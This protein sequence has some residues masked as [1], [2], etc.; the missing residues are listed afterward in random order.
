MVLPLVTRVATVGAAAGLLLL[1]C[2]C[3]DGEIPAGL[4]RWL[5]ALHG[6]FVCL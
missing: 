6:T 3:V 2:W 4:L 1:L 5:T